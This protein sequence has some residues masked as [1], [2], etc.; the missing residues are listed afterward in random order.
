M[1]FRDRRGA[2]EWCG[3]DA[4]GPPRTGK[5]WWLVVR[6]ESVVGQWRV[7]RTGW[8]RDAKGVG[9]CWVPAAD[10]GMAIEEGVI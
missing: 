5:G 9:C 1:G 4:A 10:A 3:A 7:G 6:N 2:E 8:P